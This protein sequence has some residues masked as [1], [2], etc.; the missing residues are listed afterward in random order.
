MSKHL[1]GLYKIGPADSTQMPG[2]L[3]GAAPDVVIFNDGQNYHIMMNYNY[4]KYDKYG[5]PIV[6]MRG[7]PSMQTTRPFSNGQTM[8]KWINIPSTTSNWLVSQTYNNHPDYFTSSGDV[9]YGGYT[10]T[11]FTGYY[12]RLSNTWQEGS[13][14]QDVYVVNGKSLDPNTKYSLSFY[15]KGTAGGSAKV[16]WELTTGVKYTKT[17]TISPT[18]Y[19]NWGQ[20]GTTHKPTDLLIPPTATIRLV[21]IEFDV[22]AGSTYTDIGAVT[23]GEYSGG[24]GP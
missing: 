9:I 24:G 1:K 8:D 22:P 12:V 23:F 2:T 13:M 11:S 20:F 3:N 16:R 5:M 15:A 17:V 18:G 19:Y 14:F 6:T 4:I 10:K 7:Y 21:T